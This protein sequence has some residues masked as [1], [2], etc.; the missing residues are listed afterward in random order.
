VAAKTG[1]S[2]TGKENVYHNWVTVFAPYDDPQI[3]LTVVV[4]NVQGGPEG[5]PAAVLPVV[6]DALEWYFSSE[7]E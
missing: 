4:E 7:R 2:Q 6:K 5:I 3:V 1:T